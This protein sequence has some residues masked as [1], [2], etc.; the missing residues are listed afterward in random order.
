MFLLNNLSSL[1]KKR[2][3]VGRGGS[4]GGT[5]GRGHKGQ[6]ARTGDHGIGRG[7]EGGQMPLNRRIPKR[8]FNNKDFAKEYA[9]VNLEQ[10]DRCFKNGDE[11]TKKELISAGIVSS[12]KSKKGQK[13]IL[14][15]I[16]GNG[17]F[18]KRLTIHAD[19][20]SESAINIIE[21]AGG[22]VHLSREV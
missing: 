11:V 15:K 20:A 2:K 8:C 12:K 3:R 16:L 9:I 1:V 19:A 7:F 6:K 10:L 22:K 4:K 13:S 18:S 17:A 21:N 14:I 5:S